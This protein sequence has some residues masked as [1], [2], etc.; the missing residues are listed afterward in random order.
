[1][2]KN[3]KLT[4]KFSIMLILIFIGAIAISGA[5]L[6]KALE[7]RAEREITS[8]ALLLID[9]MTAVRSYTSDRVNPLLAARLETEP[10]FIPETVPAYSATEVFENLRRNEDYKNF[11][12]KEA[13]LNPTN[14]RDKA[15]AFETKIV[16]RFRNESQ[17]KEISGFRTVPGGD[18]FYIARPLT[19]KQESCLRCHSTP[20]NAPKS[21]L[22]TYG[23]EWGFGWKMNEIVAAQVI[24]VPAAEIFESTKRSLS[25]VMGILLGIFAII[26]LLINFFL[27]RS[28][29]QPIKQMSKVAQ[30]VSTG[31]M[32]ADF[33]SSSNDEIGV[34][35]ASFNRM[36]SSLEIAMNLLQ[37][38]QTRY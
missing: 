20:E 27:K 9:S 2:L 16:E 23:T 6:S 28:V 36:K 37:Q 11:F 22:A 10:V 33:D 34:L 26:I 31:E 15:D 32:G 19:I 21:Q 38:Q 13:T 12:Y 25:L 17:T 1:M 7:H 24:S 29:I 5:A 18:V 4:T 3:L 30:K 8:Q 35:A 14:L